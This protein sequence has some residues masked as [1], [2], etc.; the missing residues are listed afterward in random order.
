MI[1]YSYFSIFKRPTVSCF[2]KHSKYLF[3]FYYKKQW[4]PNQTFWLHPLCHI[5]TPLTTG[6]RAN[7][8]GCGEKATSSSIPNRQCLTAKGFSSAF[9]GTFPHTLLQLH[10]SLTATLPIPQ[11]QV[12]LFRRPPQISTLALYAQ[13]WNLKSCERPQM[14]SLCVINMV[15]PPW[16]ELWKSPG[17]LC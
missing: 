7:S 14:Q 8:S 17:V 12:T 9:Q 5:T 2:Q 15:S 11:H 3:L 13:C 16:A 10:C 4:N 6:S 1:F